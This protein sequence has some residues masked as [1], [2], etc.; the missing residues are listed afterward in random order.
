MTGST[1]TSTAGTASCS[2]DEAQSVLSLLE[3]TM[4][5]N[6]YSKSPQPEWIQRRIAT[7]EGSLPPWAAA[8]V[9]LPP[10]P[11]RRPAAPPPPPRGC[12]SC[13][14]DEAQSVLSLLEATMAHNDYSKSPQPEWIQ[15]RIATYE[16]Q[17]AALG[18]S[19]GAASTSSGSTTG[20]TS[21]STAGTASCSGDEAQSVLS[22]LEATMAHNDYS[23]SPQPGGSSGCHLQVSLPATPVPLPPAP[24]SATGSTSH[25][26]RGYRRRFG[27]GRGT[28]ASGYNSTQLSDF[29][30]TGEMW[31][32][33]CHAA[34]EV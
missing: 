14:G 5:H 10:A 21:T 17:L 27:R 30:K 11:A 12:A 25:L 1:S 19:T 31:R 16:S 3:A 15:R 4:A 28:A 24:G 9:P 6:D 13:S 34:R 26:H 2:G 22:L 32:R 18:C 20:S 29:L 23:K 7:Y 8:R 33:D